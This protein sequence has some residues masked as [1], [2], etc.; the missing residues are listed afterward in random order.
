MTR[1]ISFVILFSGLAKTETSRWALAVVA[2]MRATP[3]TCWLQ[4]LQLAED[5]GEAAEL[6]NHSGWCGAWLLIGVFCALHMAE[7]LVRQHS[8][9]CVVR[10]NVRVAGSIPAEHLRPPEKEQWRHIEIAVRLRKSEKLTESAWSEEFI[11]GIKTSFSTSNQ[12]VFSG[13]FISQVKVSSVRSRKTYSKKGKSVAVHIL[14]DFQ[15]LYW[16]D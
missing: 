2:A 5:A 4:R 6:E 10:Q 1:N 14:S 12:K 9:S 11:S 15:N 7:G 8:A 16:R 3:P 13:R